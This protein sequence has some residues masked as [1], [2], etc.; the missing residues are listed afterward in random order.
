MPAIARGLG[1]GGI[2]YLGSPDRLPVRV[3]GPGNHDR[4]STVCTPHPARTRSGRGPCVEKTIPPAGCVCGRYWKQL[5]LQNGSALFKGFPGL[6]IFSSGLNGPMQTQPARVVY[7]GAGPVST[8]HGQITGGFHPAGPGCPLC[9]FPGPVGPRRIEPHGGATGD[10]PAG[11]QPAPMARPRRA[12][13]QFQAEEAP[14][15]G[16]HSTGEPAGPGRAPT[17]HPG[18]RAS[19]KVRFC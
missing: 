11:L 13:Q 10:T 1:S 18:N 5:L 12:E 9:G 16:P 14:P 19:T 3:L 2:Y 8:H 6:D 7:H 17:T 15:P 4:P